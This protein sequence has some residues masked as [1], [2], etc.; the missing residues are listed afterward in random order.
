MVHHVPDNNGEIHFDRDFIGN[1]DQ[2]ETLTVEVEGNPTFYV[3]PLSYVRIA[4][5]VGITTKGGNGS[6]NYT[7]L[8]YSAGSE[9]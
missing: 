5:S 9:F 2:D 1:F 8:E 6:Q 3:Q 4:D 7:A